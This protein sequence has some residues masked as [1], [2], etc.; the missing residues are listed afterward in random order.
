LPALTLVLLLCLFAKLTAVA[1]PLA[2]ASTTKF[3]SIKLVTK[4]EWT[5]T[6]GH[7]LRT[8]IRAS[9]V[10]W[11]LSLGTGSISR[12]IN[13]PYSY[14]LAINQLWAMLNYYLWRRILIASWNKSSPTKSVNIL[15]LLSCC[16]EVKVQP[17]NIS[18]Q[19]CTGLHLFSTLCAVL[20]R[21]STR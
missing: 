17:H 15:L 8:M 19:H 2:T 12:K 14:K 9:S 3:Y 1:S 11:K 4:M 13:H 5:T 10:E 6:F 20:C 16:D 7:L 18:R 21:R